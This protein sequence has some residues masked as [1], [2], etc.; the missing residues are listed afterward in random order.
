MRKEETVTVPEMKEMTRDDWM[1]EG[2]RRFGED[3]MDWRFVCCNCGH[4]QAISDFSELSRKGIFKGG[5]SDAY[6]S[7]IGRFD[8]RIPRSQI[9]ELGDTKGKK[10]CNY[11]LGGLITLNKLVVLAE[12]G[13]RHPVFEFAEATIKDGTISPDMAEG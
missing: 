3:F 1:L 8:D 7:C 4:V 11:T 10:Y 9:G 12:D 5:P 13:K 2:K 6:F